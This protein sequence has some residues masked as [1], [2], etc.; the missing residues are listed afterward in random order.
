MHSGK[1]GTGEPEMPDAGAC[2]FSVSMGKYLPFFPCRI[3][4][5]FI[6]SWF[7]LSSNSFSGLAFEQ[8]RVSRTRG[9][10][11]WCF[12]LFS[13]HEQVPSFFSCR[14]RTFSAVSWYIFFSVSSL[15]TCRFT[16]Y[17][18]SCSGT[19]ILASTGL[20]NPRCLMLVLAFFLYPWA[21]ISF[22]PPVES[23]H[24]LSFPDSFCLLTPSQDSHSSKYG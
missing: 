3:V 20:A 22:F 16:L 11:C 10:W 5:F 12:H 23:F 8:V 4:P 9:A 6:I 13:I 21:S 24:L 19:C 14:F 7:F 15:R 17:Y 1:Y 2:F 18:N